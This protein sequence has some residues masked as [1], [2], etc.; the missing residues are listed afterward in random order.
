M[1]R[2]VECQSLLKISITSPIASVYFGPLSLWN[3]ILNDSFNRLHA[4]AA[5]SLQNIGTKRAAGSCK[6]IA[7]KNVALLNVIPYFV[8]SLWNITPAQNVF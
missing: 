5:F 4:A 6:K 2:F 7:E 8:S 1:K 3:V